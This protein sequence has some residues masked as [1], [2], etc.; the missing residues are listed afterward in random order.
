MS[1]GH[2]FL[3]NVPLDGPKKAE[4]LITKGLLQLSFEDR[5]AIDEEVHGVK[6]LSPKETPELL[7]ESMH[8]LSVELSKI[9]IKVAFDKSQRLFADNT[10][11]NTA[12]FRLRFLRCHFFDAQKAAVHIVTFLDFVDELFDDWALQRPIEI[13]DFSKAEMKILRSGIYQL[14][15]YRDRSGRPIYTELGDMGLKLDLKM[16]VSFSCLK[17]LFETRPMYTKE[18]PFNMV[19]LMNTVSIA[20]RGTQCNPDEASSLPSLCCK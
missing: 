4:D 12:D 17:Q 13:K 15:P 1:E 11:I 10:Y 14:L 16:R 5:N 19:I 9:P 8:Q 3:P 20:I 18:H 6:N 7:Q 2:K